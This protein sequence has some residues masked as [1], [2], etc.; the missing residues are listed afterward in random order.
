MQLSHCCFQIER[1]KGERDRARKEAEDAKNKVRGQY[2][3]ARTDCNFCCLCPYC[4]TGIAAWDHN[5]HVSAFQ[6]SNAIMLL[7]LHLY[8][9]IVSK[10]PVWVCPGRLDATD[11]G[12]C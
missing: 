8:D 6:Y 7:L 1:V 4:V 5:W 12:G 3:W 2:V 10:V 11:W 9:T